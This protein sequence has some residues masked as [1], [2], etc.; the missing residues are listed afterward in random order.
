MLGPDG[1]LKSKIILGCL[2]VPLDDAVRSNYKTLS[3]SACT[4]LAVTRRINTS[5]LQHCQHFETVVQ[6]TV[7]FADQLILVFVYVV[8]MAD[9]LST[10]AN[11]VGVAIPALRAMRLLLD[12]IQNIVDAPKAVASLKEDLRSLEVALETLKAVQSPD[13]ESLGQEVVEESKLAISTCAKACDEFK[14]DLSRWT[15][16]SNNGKFSWHDRANV[17]FFK[18]QRMKSLSRKLQTCQIMINTTVNIATLY[19]FSFPQYCKING[20]SNGSVV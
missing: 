10:A 20:P 12:D 14:N 9:P 3:V 7:V 18:Q 1:C 17:G 8:N 19:E 15:R 4:F 6:I 13:W 11:I 16:H 2:Q 5:S